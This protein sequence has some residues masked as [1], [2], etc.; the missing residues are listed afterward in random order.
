[1]STSAAVLRWL[2]RLLAILYALFLSLFAFDVWEGVSFWQGLAGFVVHLLPVYFV[3]FALVVGWSWPRVGGVLFL[4]LAVG[5]SLAFGW[6]EAA[7]LAMMAG[8]LVVIGVLFLLDRYVS[9]YRL[10]PRY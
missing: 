1:M 2:P 8:P 4:A 9:E 3:L 6:R 10:R 7:L 5:F